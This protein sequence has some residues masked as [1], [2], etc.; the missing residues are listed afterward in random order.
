MLTKTA[1]AT[2]LA[3]FYSSRS[4]HISD[5]GNNQ[6]Y[7]WNPKSGECHL[8]KK[9]GKTEEEYYYHEGCS[10][11]HLPNMNG[12]AK[13][14]H[15]TKCIGNWLGQNSKR[16]QTVCT[17]CRIQLLWVEFSTLWIRGYH[18]SLWVQGSS[19]FVAGEVEG[20][21][22]LL[23]RMVLRRADVTSWIC[24]D[25]KLR[26]GFE[27]P[28]YVLLFVIYCATTLLCTFHQSMY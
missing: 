8:I 25:I 1:T 7:E 6:L 21:C 4:A 5:G 28:D 19:N 9:A 22:N 13:N 11:T 20:K 10:S 24:Y 15:P 18:L 12:V 26:V 17:C 2:A 16:C 27:P 14:A 23:C 3:V